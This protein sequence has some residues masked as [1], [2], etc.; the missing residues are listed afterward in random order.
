[1]NNFVSEFSP[2]R[3]SGVAHIV[4]LVR[5]LPLSRLHIRIG[6]LPIAEPLLERI[7]GVGLSQ[8]RTVYDAS[9]FMVDERNADYSTRVV[10]PQ[11]EVDTIGS[12][13]FA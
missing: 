13:A 1:M 5:R 12:Q 3:V 2:A 11:K 10:A 9:G 6:A 7:G 4:S 8:T